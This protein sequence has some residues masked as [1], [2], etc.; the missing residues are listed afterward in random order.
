ML[1]AA[2]LSILGFQVG[3]PISGLYRSWRGSRKADEAA[4][5]LGTWLI[6]VPVLLLG[7]FLT[8]TT[9]TYSRLVMTVWIVAAPTSIIFTRLLIRVL[10]NFFRVRG[11][12]TRRVVIAG[13]TDAGIELSSRLKEMRDAGNRVLGI[14]DDRTPARLA[15]DNVTQQKLLGNLETLVRDA[16]DGKVDAVYI[17]LPLRAERRIRDIVSRLA[18][19]TANVYVVTDLFMFDLMNARWGTVA[20]MPVVSVFDTPF[21]GLGGWVKRAEDIVLSSIIL[22]IISIPMIFISIGVKLSSPGPVFF[23]QTRYG[24]KGR[25]IGVL[26]FRSMTTCDNGPVVVQAQKND[27]RIT[28]FGAF[29]RRTS[30]DELPQFINVLTGEMSVVGPRPHAVAH[31]ELYRPQI[32]GYMLRHKVKPGITGWAQV[33][34]WRGETEA[35]EKMEQRVEHD[36]FY[37]DNWSLFWDLKIVF[38]T[39]FGRKVRANAL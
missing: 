21:H 16:R 14:Y 15:E 13:A 6:T 20:E 11:H 34:G 33:N 23:R 38:L 10:L 22:C 29:L 5:V 25:P 4:A 18:D 2:A 24:L 8:K 12:N 9:D 19:T 27:A 31:N 17:A 32:R 28:K 1:A 30:L 7:A 3:A 39:V 26:E 35:V 37:I 36:L